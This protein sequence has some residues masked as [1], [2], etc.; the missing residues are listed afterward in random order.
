MIQA[1]ISDANKPGC[2][3][4]SNPS[5]TNSA[6]P[7]LIETGRSSNGAGIRRTDV[8]SAS[9]STTKL[10]GSS[11]SLAAA[12]IKSTNFVT[13]STGER[14]KP[15]GF[16]C[17]QCKDILRLVSELRS[18]RYQK[19]IHSMTA[20]QSRRSITNTISRSK[21]CGKYGESNFGLLQVSQCASNRRQAG[22]Y[23]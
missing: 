14:C 21:R 8:W 20:E 13:T 23:R 1:P 19:G 3:D 11:V 15:D 12:A 22:G 6:R 10:E 9:T 7:F 4:R 17:Y 2:V 16:R 5:S 18:M